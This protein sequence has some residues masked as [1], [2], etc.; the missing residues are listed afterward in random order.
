MGAITS[1]RSSRAQR[2]RY[3]L[4]HKMYHL[5]HLLL[6]CLGLAAAV[7]IGLVVQ[8]RQVQ[9]WTE[10]TTLWDTEYEDIETHEC[11][12]KWVPVCKTYTETECSTENRKVCEKTWEGE[13]DNIKWVDIPGTCE[14]QPHDECM[15]VTKE[16]C[17][18][19]AKK[20]CE[21]K[22]KRIPVRVSRKVP[23]KVCDDGYADPL[24]VSEVVGL[25]S[26]KASSSVGGQ[27]RNN[28]KHSKA[29]DSDKD[30]SDKDSD[31]D[32]SDEEKE[33]KKHKKHKKDSDED[34]D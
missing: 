15:D 27:R 17:T 5:C 24:S 30:S 34:E 18:K 32:S 1:P 29:K 20:M 7:P 10:Y 28:K 16:Q 31:E 14:Y 3:I 2:H 12:T 6:A 9:C 26:E 13:G 22:H 11:V 4:L 23:K 21:N 25:K 33:R 19:N 8:D